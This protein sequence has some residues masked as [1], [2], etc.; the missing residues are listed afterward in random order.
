MKQITCARYNDWSII[1]AYT[2]VWEFL[3]SQIAN[4]KNLVEAKLVKIT[5]EWFDI[6]KN[7]KI[8]EEIYNLNQ[9]ILF[10]IN[11]ALWVIA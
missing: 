1:T 9:R 2:P 5:N 8:E 6:L 7:M 11:R 3:Q 4:T 10:L